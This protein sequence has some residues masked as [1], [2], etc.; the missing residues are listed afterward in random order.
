MDSTCLILDNAR[1]HRRED[2][3]RITS[4]Y[5]FD[6][7]FLS[8]YSYMLQP[9]ENAFSKIK[10]GV[11]SKLR[12]G[13]TGTLSEIIIAET[14]NINSNDCSGYCRYIIRNNINCAAGLAYVHQ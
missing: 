13:A 2:I 3:H 5:G 10:N 7:K 6:F 12:E 9:I 1:I 14:T 4:E 8:P 11:R